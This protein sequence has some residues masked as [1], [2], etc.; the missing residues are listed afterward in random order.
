MHKMCNIYCPTTS[1]TTTI[2][3]IKPCIDAE[4]T[5]CWPEPHWNILVIYKLIMS[6]FINL[7]FIVLSVDKMGGF[8]IHCNSYK[9]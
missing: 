8:L 5:E 2:S 6:K 4:V 1:Q 7:K 9:H 3:Y